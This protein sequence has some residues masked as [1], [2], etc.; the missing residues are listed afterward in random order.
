MTVI[1]VSQCSGVKKNCWLV[2]V[3]DKKNGWQLDRVL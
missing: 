2:L 1:F 3:Y